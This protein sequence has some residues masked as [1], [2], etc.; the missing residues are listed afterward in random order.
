M[1][2]NNG[3]FE[4]VRVRPRVKTTY[5]D[6]P[7]IWYN[8]KHGV[9]DERGRFSAITIN[10]MA[11]VK[12]FYCLI[13]MTSAMKPVWGQHS[14]DKW[15]QDFYEYRNNFY[16]KL[17][18]IFYDYICL[19][20]LT[21]LRHA[22]HHSNWGFDTFEGFHNMCRNE[23]F[24]T[25][26]KFTR[27]SVL[28]TGVIQFNE[29][30]NPWHRQY[31][32]YNWEMIAKAGLKYGV[33]SDEVFIDHC[34]DLEHNNGNIFDKGGFIFNC[35]S[36]ISQMLT[37][38]RYCENPIDLFK[39]GQTREIQKLIERGCNIGVFTT[40]IARCFIEDRYVISFDIPEQVSEI[41]SL[42]D[43][44]VYNNY[45]F[46]DE[47]RRMREFDKYDLDDLIEFYH[48]PYWGD[49]DMRAVKIFRTDKDYDDGYNMNRSDYH[50]KDD[51]A[52][53]W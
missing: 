12:Q 34:F 5:N 7:R 23:V 6:R 43:N 45:F 49:E 47:D 8:T 16:H 19:I 2:N 29:F 50:E 1:E 48:S 10:V 46:K 41:T 11:I 37:T 22:N 27:K 28:E 52:S 31:G 13:A 25:Y 21:E 18:K 38:K 4:L 51:D 3:I 44:S 32:G 36:G 17:A 42:Y 9:I 24:N 35:H 15:I 30:K 14:H 40:E 39:W 20:V 33:Y 26:R 53:S